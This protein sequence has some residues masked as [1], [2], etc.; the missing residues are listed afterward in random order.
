MTWIVTSSGR[1]FH[2]DNPQ[3]RQIDIE[4]IA[5]SLSRSA[6]FNGHG[7]HTYSVAQHSVVVSLLVSSD[8]A[9]KALLHDAAEAYFGDIVSPLKQMFPLIKVM[10]EH[11]QAVIYRKFGLPDEED[12]AIKQ[13][14]LVALAT[15]RRDL[16]LDFPNLTPW[17]ILKGI[18]PARQRIVPVGEKAA[19]DMF[20]L[21]F[22]ELQGA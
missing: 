2:F 4:D 10:E 11:A 22:N 8:R 19:R 21:R 1:E 7:S 16:G 15:E 9:L 5:T 13:A 12:P 18:S 3:P 6:R 20:M 17:R 14:D